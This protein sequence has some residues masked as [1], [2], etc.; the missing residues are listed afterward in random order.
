MSPRDS[1][2][3]ML[4]V[5]RHAQTGRSAETPSLLAAS[6]SVDDEHRSEQRDQG[7]YRKFT[8][9]LAATGDDESENDHRRRKLRQG[10]RAECTLPPE[11]RSQH[12]HELDVTSSHAASAHDGDQKHNSPAHQHAETSFNHV[13][14]SAGH[15]GETQRVGQP[16]KGDHIGDQA[17]PQIEDHHQSQG[18]EQRQKLPPARDDAEPSNRQQ[19]EDEGQAGSAGERNWPAQLE[20]PMPYFVDGD[21]VSA[22]IM[23]GAG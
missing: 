19:R 23:R 14:T 8:D 17:S 3:P 6:R 11:R 12:R 10:K 1:F 16:W 18:S 7:A 22:G 4:P 9:Q 2:E 21:S 15:G 13:G 5:S 20:E